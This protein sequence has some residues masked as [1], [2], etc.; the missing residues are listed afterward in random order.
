MMKTLLVVG[1]LALTPL[2][3][4]QEGFLSS[5]E[6]RARSTLAQQPAWPTPLVTPNSTL[7]QLVRTDF[8]RQITPTE[9]ST[10]NYG[11]GKG[12]NLAPRLQN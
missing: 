3:S 10:W 1:L 2:A 7:V 6:D 12:V 8:V 11:N 9:I 4:A 5:W